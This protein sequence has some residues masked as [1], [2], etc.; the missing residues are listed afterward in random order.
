MDLSSDV[1]DE[2]INVG[3]DVSGVLR[4]TD[5]FGEESIE[6]PVRFPQQDGVDFHCAAPALDIGLDIRCRWVVS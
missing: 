6:G 4:V 2:T 3:V 5:L 1:S